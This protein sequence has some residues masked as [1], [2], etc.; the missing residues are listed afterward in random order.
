[1]WITVGSSSS[2]GI[3]GMG[4]EIRL[5]VDYKALNAITRPDTYPLPRIDDLLQ[6]TIRTA[7]MPSM[8]LKAGYWQLSV[9]ETD[10]DKTAFITP[11]GTYRFNHMPFG[12]RNAPMTFL[13]LINHFKSGL[14]AICLLAYLDDL[15]LLSPRWK[16]HLAELEIF[17]R[18]LRQFSLRVNREKC[19][20]CCP[21]IKYLG[22]YLPKKASPRTQRKFEPSKAWR[23]LGLWNTCKIFSRVVPGTEGLSQISLP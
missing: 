14:G 13:R 20:F 3:H 11:F 18:R 1:M 8:D 7:F 5:C 22:I 9:E 12:L 6:S 21:Q 19:N 10:K 2:D 15:I 16:E 4:G 23:H 17:F